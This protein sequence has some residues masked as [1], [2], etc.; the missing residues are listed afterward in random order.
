MEMV[1]TS[2]ASGDLL[3]ASTLVEILSGHSTTL[4]L[5][6]A[7]SAEV[8]PPGGAGE[9]AARGHL[10]P[11]GTLPEGQHRRVGAEVTCR[12]IPCSGRVLH[13]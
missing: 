10:R 6:P 1:I 8:T 7:R 5:L 13:R 12:Y 4:Y 2:A 9:L 11:W 3:A